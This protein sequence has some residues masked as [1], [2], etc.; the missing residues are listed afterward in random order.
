MN[1]I[2]IQKI[3][4][5]LREEGGVLQNGK[6]ASVRTQEATRDVVLASF[7]LLYELGFRLESAQ[8]LRQK[9]IRALVR[10]WWLE[11]KLHPKTLQHNISRLKRFAEMMNR[12]QIIGS[13]A[14]YLPEVDP[15]LFKIEFAA[16]TSRTPASMNLDINEIFRMADV[17]NPRFGLMLRMAFHF[18]LRC[19]EL[20]RF[21]PHRQDMGT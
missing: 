14:S 19:T 17:K 21:N 3:E 15:R 1:K 18:G 13:I 9:H 12:P 11:K 2:F 5:L 10:H 16:K 20:L 8:E 6:K 4:I 7:R